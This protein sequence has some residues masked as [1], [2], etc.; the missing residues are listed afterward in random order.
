[1]SKYKSEDY[2]IIAVKLDN[3]ILI[4]IKLVRYLSVLKKV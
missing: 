4:I 1:M 3:V 2:K